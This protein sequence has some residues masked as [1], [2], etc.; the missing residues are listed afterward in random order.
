[1]EAR[2][3]SGDGSPRPATMQTELLSGAATTLAVSS[4]DGLLGRRADWAGAACGIGPTAAPTR[5]AIAP[6]SREGS[7]T[8]DS[9][10]GRRPSPA[11]RACQMR[12]KGAQCKGMQPR[13]AAM[14]PR[15]RLLLEPSAYGINDNLRR[16]RVAGGGRCVRPELGAAGCGWATAISMWLGPVLVRFYLTRAARRKHCPHASPRWQ[17]AAC[18]QA[19]PNAP[20]IANLLCANAAGQQGSRYARWWSR[21]ALA[22]ML[23]LAPSS[24]NPAAS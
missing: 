3:R 24:C 18:S 10:A 4:G 12:P 5:Q 7:A 8:L 13:A 23:K 1:M 6:A 19:L 15:Q 16:R 11:D 2:Q 20:M 9:P 22:V 21:D 14:D 17:P